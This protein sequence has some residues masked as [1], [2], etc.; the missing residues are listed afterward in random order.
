MKKERKEALL[1]AFPPVPQ[2]YTD[3]MLN[4]AKKRVTANFVIFLTYGNELFARCYHRYY[5]G[6]IVER[7]RY[8]FAKDG[9]CRYG[10]E[11]G[12]S[13]TIRTEFREP[14]FCSASYGYNF[15]NSYSMLNIDAVKQSCMRYS[16][17][18]MYNGSLPIEYLKFYIKHPNVEYI[19][20]SG[21]G[22]VIGETEVGYYWSVRKKLSAYQGI[23]WKSNNLLKML[24]L[25]RDE[26]KTLIG[27][28]QFYE[29]YRAWKEKYPQ[30]K[31]KELLTLA[32]VFHWYFEEAERFLQ[33]TGVR[34][35]RLAEYL[36]G[37]G[38]MPYDYRDYLDQC[39]MLQYDLHDTAICMPHD[40]VAMHTR[41]SQIIKYKQSE[42]ERKQFEN[43]Y[44]IRKM[45]E[46]SSGDYIIRQPKNIGEI[47]AEGAALSHCVGGYASRHAKGNL[48]IMFLRRK[49]EP[50]KPFYTIE[51]STSFKIV[52][53]R[54]YK[55]N[56]VNGGGEEKPEEIKQLERHYQQYL[57][58]IKSKKVRKTA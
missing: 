23:N 49:S 29:L 38:I 40:F 25:N 56:S 30:Y 28:E 22:G 31:P 58:T 47:I 44:L 33:I 51:V 35:P 41:L 12:L 6:D 1:R 8:V 15:D 55:N 57:N 34:L 13:W 21:Y 18:E 2:K 26:F 27:S 46:F 16:C 36:S 4:S 53:C 45:L 17:I 50:D 11:D 24:G 32:K 43:N 5:N 48:T 10:S 9:C 42:E 37:Q 7:Q 39:G 3:T 54:G 19:M 20:K 52:Q 14:V